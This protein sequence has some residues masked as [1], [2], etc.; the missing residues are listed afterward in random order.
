ML[1]FYRLPAR[2][3]ALLITLALLLP[4]GVVASPEPQ[5]ITYLPIVPK[6]FLAG[7]GNVKGRVAEAITN[8][9]IENASV[10]YQSN[11]ALTNYNGD[12]LLHNLPSGKRVLTVT[13][14]P[15]FVPTSSSVDVVDNQEVKLN[16]M[17]V[18]NLP[19]RI[20]QIV[21]TWDSTTLCWPNPEVPGMCWPNDL[22]AH[23]W[24]DFSPV[25]T[26]T[27]HIGYWG[28]ESHF[29]GDDSCETLPYACLLLD[30]TD[31][32]KPEI[33]QLNLDGA[34]DVGLNAIYY[35]GVRNPYQGQSGVPKIRE[36]GV[37]VQ[38]YDPA[39]LY[40]TY[41]IPQEGDENFWYVFYLDNRGTSPVV[42]DANCIV[43]YYSAYNDYS[44]PT[45]PSPP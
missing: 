24:V 31:G 10:C 5:L 20:R 17:L 15:E 32:S 36:M 18:R 34:M 19:G 23:L 8:E 33:V 43:D 13:K 6:V 22:D 25:L 37:M 29:P 45:C 11:C 39:G 44:P 41:Q 26:Q 35:F 9:P 2:A 1:S 12:Y 16:F 27:W 30:D 42:T 3:V 28:G 40:R 21:V 4:A 7:P 38:L 14:E